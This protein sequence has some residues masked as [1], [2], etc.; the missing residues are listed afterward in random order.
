M[1]LPTISKVF[2]KFL[3]ERLDSFF[4]K[5]KL[6]YSKQFG[7]RSKRSTINVVAESTGKIRQ[8]ST[9]TFKCVLLDLRKAFDSSNYAILLAKHK[10]Q[11]VKGVLLKWLES[12]LKERR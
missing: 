10:N 2:H 5:K 8:G 4:D 1:I 11:G 9:D 12:T 3:Y 7:F 6:L